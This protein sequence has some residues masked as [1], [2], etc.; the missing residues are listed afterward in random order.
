MERIVDALRQGPKEEFD[1]A[2][3]VVEARK[4]QHVERIAESEEQLRQ[5]ARILR[6]RLNASLRVQALSG[7]KR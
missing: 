7:K 4:I 3:R 5:R 6:G 2:R 1:L